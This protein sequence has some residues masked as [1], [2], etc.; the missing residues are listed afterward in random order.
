MPALAKLATA[1]AKMGKDAPASQ[2]LALARGYI[3]ASQIPEAVSALRNATDAAIMAETGQTAGA[4]AAY[5]L[6]CLGQQEL[7]LTPSTIALNLKE[8]LHKFPS[9][10]VLICLHY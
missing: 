3:L 5:I 1:I 9:D 10:P 6:H 8:W 2:H 7:Q 4:T